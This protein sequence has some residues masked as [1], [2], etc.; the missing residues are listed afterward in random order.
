MRFPSLF[1]AALCAA[2]VFELSA[3]SIASIMPKKRGGVNRGAMAESVD[4]IPGSTSLNLGSIPAL[5]T[6]NFSYIVTNKTEKALR[7]GRI[8][9]LCP[10]QEV[11]AS[12]N[13][14]PP[15]G[16]MRV[17]VKL[18]TSKVHTEKFTRVFALRFDGLPGQMQFQYSG[19]TV[20]PFSGVPEGPV[21]LKSESLPAVW[22]NHFEIG[23][24]SG[25]EL[26]PPVV[27]TDGSLDVNVDSKC[28]ESEGRRTL[29][30]DVVSSRGKAGLG[31]ASV[32]FPV[33]DIKWVDGVVLKLH[34]YAGRCLTVRPSRVILVKDDDVSKRSFTLMGPLEEE[35]DPAKLAWSPAPEGVT[36]ESGFKESR[37][38]KKRR[39]SLRLSVPDRCIPDLTT[40]D[41]HGIQF[42]YPG[43]APVNVY[44]ETSEDD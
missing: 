5:V 37:R 4:S 31:T 6:T 26:L 25:I 14:I 9:S 12:T 7:L 18:D 20:Q 30:V 19:R 2:S 33:K 43:F 39:L 40:N 1:A 29:L 8:F 38:Q 41:I 36:V 15:K 27:K 42:S 11:V 3:G 35:F 44:V 24:L 22:T 23:I 21:E 13:E 17:D 10:C 28:V 16:T 32:R 34:A